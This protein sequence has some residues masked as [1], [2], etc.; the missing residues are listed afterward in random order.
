MLDKTKAREI[1]HEYANRIQGFINPSSVILFGSYVNGTPNRWSDID[2]AV[3]V[4]NYKGD[5]SKT[6]SML[7]GLKW[8]DMFTDIEPHLLD[9]SHDPNGFVRHV[10]STGEVVYK[11]E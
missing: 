4:K 6:R 8:D 11:A 9:E 2:V 7:Y 5:W 1:A 3:L 10:I